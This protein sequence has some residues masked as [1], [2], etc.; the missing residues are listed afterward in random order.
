MQAKRPKRY[1]E[2]F[3]TQTQ[4]GRKSELRSIGKREVI[5]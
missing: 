2:R 5:I 4:E 3:G 1:W